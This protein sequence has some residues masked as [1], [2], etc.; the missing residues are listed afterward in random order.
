MTPM[1]GIMAS[2]RQAF[3]PASLPN[4]AGWWDPSDASSVTVSSG[5]VSQV[6]DKSGNGRHFVQATSAQQP[7]YTTAGRNGLN[8]LTF[9][10]IENMSP[11]TTMSSTFLTMMIVVKNDFS[12]RTATSWTNEQLNQQ[13]SDGTNDIW[14]FQLGTGG[15]NNYQWADGAKN[16]VWHYFSITRPLT[17]TN[18][19]ATIDGG[20]SW[21]NTRNAGHTIPALSTGKL[22]IGRR[23]TDNGQPLYGRIG[24][25]ILYTDIKDS[26]D[27]GKLNTYLATKWGF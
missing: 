12:N 3:T 1:L 23:S 7:T 2:S 6:N 27:I 26:T 25:V 19:T 8:V 14:S 16:D 5:L 17:G 11:S 13:N 9:N 22:Q 21:S 24:E 20:G 18:P 10:G 4:L 15:T